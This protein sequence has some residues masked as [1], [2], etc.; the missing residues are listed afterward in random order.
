M[1]VILFIFAE[2]K[3]IIPRV[4]FEKNTG[5]CARLDIKHIPNMNKFCDWLFVIGFL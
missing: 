4:L 2:Y 3:Y 5:V 1:V